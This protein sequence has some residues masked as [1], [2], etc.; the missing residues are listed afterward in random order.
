MVFRCLLAGFMFEGV[1][2][3]RRGWSADKSS[4]NSWGKNGKFLLTLRACLGRPEQLE[5][6]VRWRLELDG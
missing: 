2:F 4:R 6:G 5:P 1:I 3:L